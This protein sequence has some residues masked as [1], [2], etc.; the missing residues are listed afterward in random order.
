MGEHGDLYRCCDCGTVQQPSLPRGTELHD[1]YREMSDDA[2]YLAEER[3]RRRTARRLLNLLGAHVPRGRL[4]DVGCGH[5]LLLDEARRRGY[6]VEGLELSAGAA[7]YARE[8][9][10]LPVRETTLEDTA[11]DGERYDAIL[12]VDVLE[13]LDDPVAAIERSY[14]LLAPGGALLIVTPDPSSLVARAAGRRWRSYLPAHCCLIP[15]KTLRELLCARGLVLA[16][17]VP[18]VHSFT[19]DYWLAG[20][21]ERAG[22][23]AGTIA[24]VAARLP[25]TVLLTVSL[26]DERVLLARRVGTCVP[27]RPL[28]GDRASAIPSWWRR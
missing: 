28:A 7:R 23:A 16:E 20:L 6:E 8:R 4:L 15:R 26:K 24:R 14:T 1:L 17:D 18:Y 10:G 27:P 21:S 11:L 3:G 9:L 2:S 25:R 12:I 19:P 22:W 5:G 13:H